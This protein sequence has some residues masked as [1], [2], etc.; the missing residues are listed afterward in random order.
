VSGTP[1]RRFFAV[2]AII[3]VVAA[4][5]RVA[6]ILGEARYD[7]EFY[8]AAYYELQARTIVDGHGFSDPFQFLPGASHEER[9]AADHPPLTVFALL[10]IAAVGDA[11]GMDEEDNQLVMRFWVGLFG[12]LAVFL[13]GL[14][15]REVMGDRTGL[16]AAGIAAV[17]PYLWI[18]DG[19]LMSETFAVCAVTGALLMTLRLRRRPRL[20]LALGLGAVCGVAALA[21]AELA[22]LA[23]LLGLPLLW[24]FRKESWAERIKV[25]GAIAVGSILLVGP[26]VAFNFSRFDEPTFI[27]TNDG[28]AMLASNCD[29]VFWGPSTGLTYLDG[30]IPKQAPPGDQ[31]EVSRVYRDRA[32]D[33]ISLRQKRWAVVLLAR[34]G[35][36]WSFFRPVDMLSWNEAEGRPSWITGLGLYF[37]YPLLALAIGGIVV[38]KRRKTIQWPLLVPPVVVTLG[39]IAAY[40]QT[41]FRVPAEPT[42]IVLAAVSIVALTRRWWP[43]R[44]TA[45][46]APDGPAAPDDRVGQDAGSSTMVASSSS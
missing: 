29:N 39:A 13:I 44:E 11:L 38:L 10:P 24:A 22:L 41:R 19:L 32:M 31:S 28:I 6:Y 3:L 20:G 42:I 5:V 23:P 40:G 43:E 14:L 30:C 9:P 1:S 17:Y 36:D 8:D 34:V 4:G 45:G 27:S 7:E 16:V 2:L 26:W 33:Y 21:R 46:P 12:L 35:R 37:Y 25:V 18:N 15:G